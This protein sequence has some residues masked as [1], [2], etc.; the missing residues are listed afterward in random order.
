MKNFIVG[1]DMGGTFIKGGVVD[2]NG[3]L[4]CSTKT[5]TPI[6]MG[7]NAIAQ[8]IGQVAEN[9][10]RIMKLMDEMDVRGFA[11]ALSEWMSWPHSMQV[12]KD[13]MQGAYVYI[14]RY[15]TERLRPFIWES[16]AKPR[17]C[18]ADAW[19]E[20]GELLVR[21]RLP[22]ARRF[23]GVKRYAHPRPLRRQ[24]ARIAARKGRVQ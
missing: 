22:G 24:D 18:Y 12:E 6:G 15:C 11:A 2:F 4:I 17:R 16:G 23:R 21:R 9:M 7:A 10:A 19:E 5:S 13:G 14:T 8:K 20:A 3:N 1:I